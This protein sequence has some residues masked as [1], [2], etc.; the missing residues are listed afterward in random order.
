M[1]SVNSQSGL[2]NSSFFKM[3]I[4]T[5]RPIIDDRGRFADEQTF[6]HEYIHYLQD[7]ATT[8]GL[9]NTSQTLKLLLVYVQEAK[10]NRNTTIKIPLSNHNFGNVSINHDLVE[11]YNGDYSQDKYRKLQNAHLKLIEHPFNNCI[12][13]Y[14][15][16]EY[17]NLVFSNGFKF[18]FGGIAI[19]ECMAYMLEVLV[20]RKEFD[21]NLSP[22]SLAYN[23]TESIYPELCDNLWNIIVICDHALMHFD[24]GTIF[25]NT[26]EYIK[27]YGL[28]FESP[29]EIYDVAK[30]VTYGNYDDYKSIF[31]V[32]LATFNESMDA[33]FI[34]DDHRQIKNWSKEIVLKSYNDI[35]TNER[36]IKY[37][38]DNVK[39]GSLQLI[40]SLIK[41]YSMPLTFNNKDECWTTDIQSPATSLYLALFD[42]FYKFSEGKDLACS[43]YNFCKAQDLN[44]VNTICLNKPWLRSKEIELCP[45]AQIWI[46]SGLASVNIDLE[47]IY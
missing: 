39:Y 15:S 31:N 14:E 8:F 29:F 37:I 6:F 2:Y 4:N 23:I 44:S 30:M 11:M 7:I 21:K 45:F 34:H 33:I 35:G 25:C 41:K 40:S 17:I 9:M 27:H 32:P 1:L 46:F 19:L 47:L 24:P 28:T 12:P 10:K 13:G 42:I 36:F 26:L 18:H 22:Y 16:V 5:D 43:L 3:V 20:F 38:Y